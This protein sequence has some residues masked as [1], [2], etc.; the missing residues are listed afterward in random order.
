MA[1]PAP[2]S[3]AS[4][5]EINAALSEAQGHADNIASLDDGSGDDV[6]PIP[7]EANTPAPLQPAPDANPDPQAAAVDNSAADVD[8][9]AVAV[10]NGTEQPAANTPDQHD[11][12]APEQHAAPARSPWLGP[13][14]YQALDTALWAVNRPF[15]WL[16]PDARRLVG[17]LALATIIV[18]VLTLALLPMLAPH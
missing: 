11:D 17:W 7:V 13:I 4:D 10:G 16:K 14:I 9:S 5:A 18:S 2:T 1:D 15:E 3:I 6:V 8:N 12:D